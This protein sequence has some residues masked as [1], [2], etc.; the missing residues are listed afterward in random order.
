MSQ[1]GRMKHPLPEQVEFRSSISLP[2]DQL[3]A[4]NLS[5]GL[6]PR[7]G[8]SC[9]DR[10]LILIDPCDKSVQSGET[11]FW[12]PP[13]AS[14]PDAQLAEYRASG[15]TAGPAHRLI[16]PQDEAVRA[17]SPFPA[18]LSSV[19]PVGAET[20][21]LLVWKKPEPLLALGRGNLPAAS[22]RLG[23]TRVR[24]TP[25]VSLRDQCSVDACPIVA[26]KNPLFSDQ[27]EIRIKL[28]GLFA[29][30]PFGKGGSPQP[31]IDRTVTDTYLLGNSLLAHSL[32][33]QSQ[34]PSIA[35]STRLSMLLNDL[36][37]AFR[38]TGRALF[39]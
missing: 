22:L 15:Q 32:F 16:L 29:P 28:T 18:L 23:Y 34:Y 33:A 9:L 25:G 26:A 10:R 11:G 14:S 38:Q 4:S 19:L 21:T 31:V 13:Q 12:Q 39:Q 35:T 6:A 2:F 3:V 20:A 1:L 5:F 37:Q 7:R 36:L 17:S 30:F 27:R 8:E 24:R